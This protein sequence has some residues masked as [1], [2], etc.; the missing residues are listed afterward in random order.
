MG[1]KRKAGRSS[2]YLGAEPVTF[3][4]IYPFVRSRQLEGTFPGDGATG[5]WPST[6][7]RVWYGWGWTPDWAWPHRPGSAWPPIEPPDIDKIAKKYRGTFYKRVR[8]LDDCI[9]ELTPRTLVGI[10]LNISNK[11]ADPPGGKIPTLGPRDLVVSTHHISV[12]RYD[13]SSNVF[14]FRN[15]WGPKWGDRGYGYIERKDLEATWWEGWVHFPEPKPGLESLRPLPTS[16]DATT[17]GPRIRQKLWVLKDRSG[18]TRQW[19][20]LTDVVDDERMAWASTVE[21]ESTL[22]I[23]ELYVRPS[24]RRRGFGAYLFNAVRQVSTEKGRSLSM[25]IPFPDANSENL[26]A[27]RK[28]I[29]SAALSI[30]TSG[31]RWAPLVASP[32]WERRT[33]PIQK[34]EYPEKPPAVPSEIVKLA[35]EFLTTAVGGAAGMFIYDAIRSWLAPKNERRIRVKIGDIEV[36]SN[37]L[38]V[39]DFRKLLL[40]V[41]DLKYEDEIRTE[42]LEAGYI[43]ETRT[44]N[45]D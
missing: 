22:E 1:R 4:T 43:V 7:S 39:E 44:R 20:E 37:Q 14:V 5:T 30:Q 38:S 13:E 41:R 2:G 34:F 25:W 23:E 8:T 19:Y 3:S 21:S 12:E 35:E 36:E 18:S 40:L 29:A 28:I 17:F 10:S 32:I 24:F 6:S 42:L 27:V 16:D 33:G 26:H 31:V 45:K 11:W 9:A 15:S